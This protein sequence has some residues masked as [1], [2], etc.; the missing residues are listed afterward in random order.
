MI[1]PNDLI[2]NLQSLAVAPKTRLL[3]K[4]PMSKDIKPTDRFHFNESFSSKFL[5]LKVGVVAGGNKVESEKERKQTEKRNDEMRG[6]II[7]AAVVRIMK[8]VHHPSLLLTFY[9]PPFFR[10]S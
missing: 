2:R 10:K 9:F 7:E 5:K 4:E 6:G 1:P 8:Y 3:I